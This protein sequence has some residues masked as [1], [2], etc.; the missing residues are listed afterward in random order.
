[1]LEKNAQWGG[2]RSIILA[3]YD[4]GDEFRWM[5]WVGHVARVGEKVNACMVLMGIP[6][7]YSIQVYMRRWHYNTSQGK[8][9]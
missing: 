2:S 8:G 9:W 4:W 6:K 1:M 7:E 3:E 5:C